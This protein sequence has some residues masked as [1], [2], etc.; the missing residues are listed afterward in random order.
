MSFAERL[1]NARESGDIDALLE[2][3]P[4]AKFLGFAL[5]REG[6]NLL[7]LMRYSDHLIGN[8][9]V[10]AI[11][12]GTL[13]ALMELTASSTLLAMTETVH[14][15]KTVNLTIE[16]LRGGHARDTWAQA[17]VIRHGRRV[18]NVRVVC[19]QEDAAKPI[20]AAN[21]HFLLTPPGQ[22]RAG[23]PGAAS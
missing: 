10:Q 21:L 23:E 9:T 8:A 18:A 16:Y 22:T 4:Y 11:H 3:I 15:P 6:E 17:E 1:V 19:W 7:G 14:V 12:G 2:L 5:V 20:A 13:G